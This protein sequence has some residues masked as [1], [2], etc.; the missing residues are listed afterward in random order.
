MSL[1]F[2]VKDEITLIQSDIWKLLG[3]ISDI[4][5]FQSDIC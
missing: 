5:L 1:N 4:C 2:K 3:D